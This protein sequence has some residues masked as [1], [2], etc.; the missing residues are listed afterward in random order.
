MAGYLYNSFV[1]LSLGIRENGNESKKWFANKEKSFKI[2]LEGSGSKV[3]CYIVEISTNKKNCVKIERLG[4]LDSNK[5]NR[6]RA[7][8]K[9]ITKKKSQTAPQHTGSIQGRD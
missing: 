4:L 3:N 1:V 8:N 7:I 9:L 5:D 6:Q 2:S